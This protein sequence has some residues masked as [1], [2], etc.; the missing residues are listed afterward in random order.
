MSTMPI[1]LQGNERQHKRAGSSVLKSIIAPR[2]HKRNPTAGN[3]LSHCRTEYLA[4]QRPVPILPPNHPHAQKALE[5]LKLRERQSRS[6]SDKSIE[7]FDEENQLGRNP[8][9]RD[10]SS[11]SL[12]GSPEKV[13]ENVQK[14]RANDSKE[15]QKPRKSKSSTSLSALL[16][17]SKSSK[18]SKGNGGNLKDKENQTPPSSAGAELP[19]IWAQFATQPVSTQQSPTK[20]PLNDWRNVE[21]ECALYTPKE[22]SPSKQR[23]FQDYHQPVLSRKVEP[24]PRPRS[25]YISSNY[26]TASF[27]DTVSGLRSTDD[28]KKHQTNP[29]GVQS[30]QSDQTNKTDSRRSSSELGLHSIGSI[31][32]DRKVS[33]N[34]APSGL[35]VAKNGSRVM[36]AVAAFNDRSR[37]SKTELSRVKLDI[38]DLDREFESLLVS[39]LIKC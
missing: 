13:R 20:V 39:L 10:E 14:P 8:H 25:A 1:P 7:V 4:S 11:K 22:Y 33:E 23:N 12:K 24:K 18:H 15:N 21:R 17:K 36:A 3:A 9:R 35:T 16:S 31:T 34:S 26:S 28:A 29:F 2:H 32:G 19:P 38:K 27:A 5:E 6:S 37:E 30:T